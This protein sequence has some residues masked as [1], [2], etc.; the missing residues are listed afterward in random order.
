MQPHVS[1]QGDLSFIAGLR[2][3]LA[4]PITVMVHAVFENSISVNIFY[5]SK[6]I[7]SYILTI[8]G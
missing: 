6:Y 1:P 8:L 3:A 2:S 4:Q 7:I 5:Y